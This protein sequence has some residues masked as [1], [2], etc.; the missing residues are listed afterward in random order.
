VIH[1]PVP[2]LSRRGRDFH[3]LCDYAEDFQGFARADLVCEDSHARAEVVSDTGDT[4][5]RHLGR[6]VGSFDLQRAFD[7]GQL[8]RLER[9]GHSPR[10]EVAADVQAD[11][12]RREGGGGR[13]PC[14][15]PVAHSIAGKKS[16]SV[17]GCI[18]CATEAGRQAGG[19]AGGQAGGE[20]KTPA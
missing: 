18:S 1:V 12:C 4:L 16:E 8:V 19:R 9:D 14:G 2:R 15:L 13:R 6:E 11:I 3:A 17:R 10:L 5:R 7:R 20:E